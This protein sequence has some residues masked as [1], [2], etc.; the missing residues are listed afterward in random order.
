LVLSGG[1]AKGAY[2]VGV[3]K[4]LYT[5]A[6][7]ATGFTPL[8]AEVFT[9]TSVGAYNATFMASRPHQGANAISELEKTWRT[10][11]ANTSDR[12][13]N[14]IFR[15]R[16]L[17][18]QGFDIGC[19]RRPVEE[20]I[21]LAK[22]SSFFA[23]FALVRG[24]NL[25]SSSAPV[26]TRIAE[27][28]D[29]SALFS[30]EPLDSLVRKTVDLRALRSSDSRLTI[31]ASNWREGKLQL[32]TKDD[33]T[34]R[35]GT[36]ALLASAAIPGI[37]PPVELDGTPYVDGGVLN[38]TPLRPAIRYG[39]NVAHVIYL[40]PVVEQIPFPQLPNTLNTLYRLYAVL[41]AANFRNDFT[42]AR[43]VNRALEI[44]EPGPR[45]PVIETDA[46]SQAEITH[47]A[48]RVVERRRREGR[49]YR[50]LII[51]RYR[52]V[53]DLGGG[54]GLLDFSS[55]NIERLID[56]GYRDAV[57]HNCETSGCEVPRR[58]TGE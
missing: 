50:K 41:E 38:N 30:V 58:R 33:I 36:A 13:G 43:N 14:G 31:A 45:R 46:P 17:P 4:A 7:P 35:F 10:D 18:L 52:P 16:G 2:E 26:R 42:R 15:I 29:L 12:C 25:I 44:T 34:E 27:T 11:I 21:E 48:A 53:N 57:N 39:A 49:P 22:D 47:L 28:V 37:F 56:L 20:V 40:D 8:E 3:M 23:N 6:S 19:L 54:E 1:S 5:G 32:F 24:M 51:H 9:G 55:E